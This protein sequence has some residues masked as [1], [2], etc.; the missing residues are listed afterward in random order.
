MFRDQVFGFRNSEPL[1]S[2]GFHSRLHSSSGTASAYITTCQACSL[3]R[4]A[5][6]MLMRLTMLMM[7]VTVKVMMLMMLMMMMIM[8]MT[9]MVKMMMMM[10]TVMVMVMMMMMTA[11]VTMMM[12]VVVS[13]MPATRAEM[14][15]KNWQAF[16]NRTLNFCFAEK[17]P[18]AH[19]L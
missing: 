8:M 6:I 12:V 15:G 13:V 4:E 1:V 3:L 14:I 19:F 7:T 11:N 5:M 17:I 16:K 10:T 9:V 2:V 18:F